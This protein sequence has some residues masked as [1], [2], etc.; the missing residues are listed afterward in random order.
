MEQV[1]FLSS[2]IRGNESALRSALSRFG[3]FEFVQLADGPS[4]LEKL[5]VLENSEGWIVAD[6]DSS[7]RK[8]DF[9]EML[10]QKNQGLRLVFV[11]HRT[12]DSEIQ[13]FLLCDGDQILL[14]SLTEN[15]I[16]QRLAVAEK[17]RRRIF[18]MEQT[19][20]SLAQFDLLT[21]ELT[22]QCVRIRLIG[23]L[24]EKVEFPVI[25]P[26]GSE[27]LVVLD[28]EHLRV[29]NSVGIK[30]WIPWMQELVKAGVHKVQMENLRPGF[31]QLASFVSG[32]VPSIGVITSFYLHYW[33]EMTDTMKYFKFYAREP[34]QR[35]TIPRRQ[36]LQEDG[37]EVVYEVDDSASLILR[38][39]K[40][41]V[42]IGE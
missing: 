34:S 21:E 40:D 32:F 25:K 38:L 3:N 18:P 24:T 31:L 9:F 2:D 42:G 39:F 33:N 37:C 41:R 26:E 6:L 11:T 36:K 20:P 16:Y 23:T 29:I 4:A 5:E 27:T 1:F 7:S 30:I 12:G 17:F 13:N 19:N 35:L 14:P 8:A 10:R 22:E 15:E 28:L